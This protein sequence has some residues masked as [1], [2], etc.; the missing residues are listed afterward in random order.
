M[1]FHHHFPG[2]ELGWTL[3]LQAVLSSAADTAFAQD[4]NIPFY[5]SSLSTAVLQVSQVWSWFLLPSSL[6]VVH[7]FRNINVP[8]SIPLT[9]WCVY[10]TTQNS[11]RLR[12][13]ARQ[14]V[15]F[16][17]WSCSV[18]SDFIFRPDALLVLRFSSFCW[19]WPFLLGLRAISSAK[20]KI[21]DVRDGGLIPI[22]YIPVLHRTWH[23]T[24]QFD[25]C[26]WLPHIDYHRTLR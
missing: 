14:A 3:S 26:H 4:P 23:Q 17:C 25:L 18:F 8:L 10:P 24:R 11:L 6:R 5:L 7:G 22:C 19:I 16:H 2:E 12:Y 20:S 1:Y 9:C 15:L 13:F 21:Q